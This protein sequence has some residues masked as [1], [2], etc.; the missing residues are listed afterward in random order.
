MTRQTCSSLPRVFQS[1][2]QGHCLTCRRLSPREGSR[3]GAH[4]RAPPFT[5]CVS[6]NGRGVRQVLRSVNPLPAPENVA[7]AL[8]LVRPA[9]AIVAGRSEVSSQPLQDPGQRFRVQAC[10]GA[11]GAGDDLRWHKLCTWSPHDNSERMIPPV[12]VV[13]R[14]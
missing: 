6:W 9:A 8:L 2:D 5:A 14:T 1:A 13:R 11:V 10:L 12:M 4:N 7:N 3:A